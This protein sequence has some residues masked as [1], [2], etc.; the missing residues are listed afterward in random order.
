MTPNVTVPSDPK[1]DYA[2]SMVSDYTGQLDDQVTGHAQVEQMKY[3]KRPPRELEAAI[4]S[5]Q[6][7]KNHFCS[8]PVLSVYPGSSPARQ[9]PRTDGSSKTIVQPTPKRRS[10][11]YAPKPSNEETLQ[12]SF[13]FPYHTR[14][15]MDTLMVG[16]ATG[17]LVIPK[18]LLV[19]RPRP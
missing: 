12:Y 2:G 7:E 14:S 17:S 15:I 4:P 18:H 19:D 3:S 10:R 6:H 5:R 1:W 8:H 11:L 13:L 9:I 16:V